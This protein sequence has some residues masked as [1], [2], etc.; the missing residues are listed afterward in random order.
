M[1]RVI[2]TSL[3][4]LL[5]LVASSVQ[6]HA[7]FVA[8]QWDLLQAQHDAELDPEKRLQL[9]T[10]LDLTFVFQFE[11]RNG[12]PD[13]PPYLKEIDG[14]YASVAEWEEF[15][16]TKLRKLLHP[17]APAL[18][19]ADGR[20]INNRVSNIESIIQGADHRTVDVDALFTDNEIARS[21]MLTVV[22][23]LDQKA[24][25]EVAVLLTAIRANK[26]LY[27]RKYKR[28]FKSRNILQY[29]LDS[30]FHHFFLNEDKGLLSPPSPGELIL[31]SK[32]EIVIGTKS[33]NTSTFSDNNNFY[34]LV[35]M[36][37]WDVFIRDFKSFVGVSLFS[38]F[39]VSTEIFENAYWGIEG[40]YSNKILFGVGFREE[41]SAVDTKMFLTVPVI[42]SPS[43]RVDS[44]LE[45]CS[46]RCSSMSLRR[47]MTMLRRG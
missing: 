46:A 31:L 35:Q 17:P 19:V 42:R 1:R 34:L 36:V 11:D 43:L 32:P 40:H 28:G 29:Y 37:G 8:G 7:Q 23:A 41:N 25:G 5:V 47:E 20:L 33:L 26:E 10:V 22:N 27:D 13:V 18:H 14:A 16:K 38:S 12:Y 44:S 9:Q 30:G 24:S 21:L 3:C 15:C 45:R 2:R 6:V 4:V 39:P